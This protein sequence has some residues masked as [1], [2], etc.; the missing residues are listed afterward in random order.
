MNKSENLDWELDAAVI[1]C[2]EIKQNYI[3]EKLLVMERGMFKP[4]LSN[5]AFVGLFV[6]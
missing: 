6:F 3:C 2:F 5:V 1:C 4:S